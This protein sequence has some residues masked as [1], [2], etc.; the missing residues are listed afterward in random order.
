MKIALQQ[1]PRGIALMIVMI[2]VFVLTLLAG[3]F[4]YSMKVE[5]RLAMNANREASDLWLGRSGVEYAR[6][7]LAQEMR[8]PYTSLNQK[9]AGGPGDDCETNGPLADVSLD[10]FQVCDK[11]ISISITNLESKANINTADENMLRQA[12]TL[13]GVDAS[14]IPTITDSILDWIDPN[15]DSKIARINGAKSD[16]YQSLTPPYPAKNGPID[17]LSELLMIK[18]IRDQPDIYSADYRPASFQKVDRFGRAIEEPAR[19]AYLV[20][21]FTPLSSGRINVNTASATVLQLIPGVDENTASAIIQQR[22]QAPFQSLNEVPV[23]PQIMPQLQR[24]GT[25]RGSTWA[26]EVTVE[27]ASRKFYAVVRTNSPRDVPILVF[28]WK[29]V[30]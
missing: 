21:L 22:D 3:A 4:A 30:E 20:D 15:A 14:E 27:G 29:D 13:V 1:A 9:W 10:N 19:T 24:Y 12:L 8:C 28:Y 25:V 23:P 2:A 6:Y 16:Y 18:G 17:D 5:T 7:I 26:V 11:K